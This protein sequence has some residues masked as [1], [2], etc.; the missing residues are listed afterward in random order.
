M[1]VFGDPHFVS[2]DNNNFTFN[3]I[4][5]YR[6][7]ESPSNRL[8]IQ[9]RLE[10]FEDT[11]GTVI[12]AIA[13]KQGDVDIQVEAKDSALQLYV[14]GSPHPLPNENQVHVV[15][16]NGV[17]SLLDDGIGIQD[18]AS[19]DSL[20]QSSSNDQL[21]V[22]VDDAGTLIVTTPGG[23]T[24]MTALQMTFLQTTVV[25][26]DSYTGETRGL[27]GVYNGDADDDFTLPNGT[28]LDSGLTEAQV[29]D[30]GLE[31]KWHSC[32]STHACRQTLF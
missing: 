3:G 12:T 16:R 28:V 22:Q 21:S 30:F 5:E 25:L 15:T 32:Q 2:V 6:L 8:S 7:L 26:T 11:G 14:Q 20:I 17:S 18:V 27:M 23:A 19:Q 1:R 9:S 4:G 24:V 13:I 10:Q 29:Y 31:C